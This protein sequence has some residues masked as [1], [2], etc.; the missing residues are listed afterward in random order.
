MPTSKRREPSNERAAEDD[1]NE[2]A[3]EDAEEEE[4]P[5][6]LTDGRK[7]STGGDETGGTGGKGGKGKGGKGKGGKGKGSTALPTLPPPPR[8]GKVTSAPARAAGQS[9]AAGSRGA[10]HGRTKERHRRSA[11]RHRQRSPRRRSRSGSRRRSESYGGRKKRRRWVGNYGTRS[12]ASGP[13]QRP[14]PAPPPFRGSVAICGEM[15]PW[16][17][18][19]AAKAFDTREALLNFVTSV[20]EACMACRT[21]LR[22]RF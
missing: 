9:S 5:E 19:G 4:E 22:R 17:P 21:A 18:Q 15:M 3:D 13:P 2:N 7:S 12:K 1:D 6:E 16:A 10:Q 11:S 14:A 20:E 8:K